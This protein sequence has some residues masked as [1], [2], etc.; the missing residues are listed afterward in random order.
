MRNITA[1]FSLFFLL[2]VSTGCSVI[3][4]EASLEFPTSDQV[5]YLPSGTTIEST[6]NAYVNFLNLQ[7]GDFFP[8]SFKIT[9]AHQLI[10][11]DPLLVE[12]PSTADIIL[13][14]HDHA[15]HL[16]FPALNKLIGQHTRLLIPQGLVAKISRQLPNANITAVSVG[17]VIHLSDNTA[18]EV[19]EAYNL[20]PH[21]YSMRMHKP[22]NRHVGYIIRTETEAIYH[23]G[24]TD[25][26]DEMAELR[27]IDVALLP[28][29]VGKTAMTIDQAVAAVKIISPTI[30]VPMHYDLGEQQAKIFSERVAHTSQ[31]FVFV[32][33]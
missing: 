5:L 25:L 26:I 23:A 19:V 32:D 7:K 6:G 22:G 1:F 14:S 8:S 12:T 17:N 2:L 24:D 20:K 10:Y 33:E 30:V 4:I 18:I 27:N 15:D 29:G 13:I 16:S 21:W 11:I 31:V 9:T 3:T 28:I